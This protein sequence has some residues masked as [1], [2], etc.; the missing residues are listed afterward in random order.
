MKVVILCGGL[1][2]RLREET[3]YRPKPLVPIGDRPIVWH[4][5]NRYAAY[6]FHEFV[7]CLGYKGE[8]IQDY[9]LNYRTATSDFTL[10]LDD[11]SPIQFHNPHQEK[12]WVITFAN[13]GQATMTGARVKRIEQYIDTD[14][15]L[16]TYGDGLADI[17]VYALLRFHESHKKIATVTGVR[18]GVG[19]FGELV[20]DGQ[21]VTRFAEKPDHDDGYI[22]GGFFVFQRDVFRYL[23]PDDS[24]VLEQEPLRGLAVDQQLMSYFHHGFWHCMDTY[25][26]YQQL[27]D[28]WNRG[29]APWT[30][31]HT[32]KKPDRSSRRLKVAHE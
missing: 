5:M 8:L 18:P 22:N 12:D 9:F 11:R 1:G 2:T 6:G 19:R 13:T 21:Q 20:L 29:Q 27:N 4:I 10:K 31:I 15:F 30:I 3:E 26:D 25:R 23:S 14:S 16:L 7:L 17:D 32:T 24:C 28:I